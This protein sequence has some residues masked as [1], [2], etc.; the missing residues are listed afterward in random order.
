MIIRFAHEAW[1][2]SLSPCISSIFY[3]HNLSL[4]LF[5][6]VLYQPYKHGCSQFLCIE[7]INLSKYICLCF[8]GFELLCVLLFF[9]L[10]VG[11]AWYK[12]QINIFSFPY[13]NRFFQTL[14]YLLHAGV[15]YDPVL[16]IIIIIIILVH[17]MDKHILRWYILV[18]LFFLLM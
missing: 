16:R 13:N 2:R 3:P 12:G 18:P 7:K 14:N 4:L 11:C 17:W 10:G 15:N 1:R 9:V 6:F 5:N 8:V